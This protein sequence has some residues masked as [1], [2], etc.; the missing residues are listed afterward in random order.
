MSV[1]LTEKRIKEIYKEKGYEVFNIEFNGYL[2]KVSFI[3][4]ENYKY[5]CSFEYI[6]YRN[7]LKPIIQNNPY[8]IENIDNFLKLKRIDIEVLSEKYINSTTKLKVMGKCGHVFEITWHKL[9]KK[10]NALCPDCSLLFSANKRRLTYKTIQDIFNQ[11]GY[12]LA[13]GQEHKKANDNF[14]C[15][16]QEGY[17][18]CLSYSDLKMNKSF[19]RI[20]SNNPF[21]NE[22]IDNFLVL[23]NY[24]IKRLGDYKDNSSLIKF[25]CS[26]SKK[27]NRSWDSIRSG[28]GVMCNTCLNKSSL[29]E[30]IV[31]QFLLE[32]NVK[33]ER[34]KSFEECKFKNKLPFDFYLYEHN[35]LIEVDGEQ[36][37]MPIRFGGMEQSESEEKYQN[38]LI[39]DDIKNNF[40][41]NNNIDL[42]RL[43][44]LEIK[45]NSFKDKLLNIIRQK[46]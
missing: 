11:K 9:Q 31:E 20:S 26:C 16:D 39:K 4:E 2:S 5:C 36:H 8:S 35:I 40:C 1:E 6:K 14:L 18:G 41:K 27:F 28:K 25:Q 32:C 3:D 37:Y 24:S 29:N 46:S 17:K 15:M 22:N 44:Y 10:K 23:K 38:Q 33:F 43:S 12:L 45:N 21:V 7:K 34:E 42:I 19:A 30:F 13:D